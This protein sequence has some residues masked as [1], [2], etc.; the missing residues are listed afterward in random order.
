MLMVEIGGVPNGFS[1]NTPLLWEEEKLSHVLAKHFA[2]PSTRSQ[3]QVRL[4]KVFTARNIERIAGIKIRRTGNLADH[5]RLFD[6]DNNEIVVNIFHHAS[7]L[8]M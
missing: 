1:G 6:S 4:G 3:E 8:V 7:F 2:L 5:L